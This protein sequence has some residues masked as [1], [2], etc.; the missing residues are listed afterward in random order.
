M[1]EL[2]SAVHNRFNTNSGI[3]PPESGSAWHRGASDSPAPP[4][5]KLKR[6][7]QPSSSATQNYTQLDSIPPKKSRQSTRDVSLSDLGAGLNVPDT[8][9]LQKVYE[10]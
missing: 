8:L 6:S 2:S 7:V 3:L 5:K 10:I 9:L 4:D 1:S